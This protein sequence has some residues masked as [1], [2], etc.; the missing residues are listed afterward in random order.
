MASLRYTIAPERN[1]TF[2]EPSFATRDEAFRAA[3]DRQ[4]SYVILEWFNGE[5]EWVG[6]DRTNPYVNADEFDHFM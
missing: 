2:S 1:A 3:E 6:S 5:S 4:S